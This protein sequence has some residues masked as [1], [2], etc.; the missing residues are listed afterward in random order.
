MGGG[1]GEAAAVATIA[2]A[3]N[4]R[5]TVG[6]NLELG[7]GQAAMIHIATALPGV[8]PDIVPCDIIS[9]LFYT[10]DILLEPLP[11]EAGV[12]HRIERAGLGVE[13]NTDVVDRYR[14][15]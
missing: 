13:L 9:H 7:I 1:I 12:A 4:V 5:C 6:S 8:Q 3:A 11:V 2:H 14:V 10:D 15:G